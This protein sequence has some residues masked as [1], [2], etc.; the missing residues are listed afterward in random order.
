MI[1]GFLMRGALLRKST[2]RLV[3]GSITED[4]RSRAAV[5]LPDKAVF[6]LHRVIWVM[7]YGEPEKGLLVDHRDGDVGHNRIANFR[8]LTNR[9][10]QMN[11]RKAR[12][13]STVRYIGVSAHRNGFAAF[14]ADGE[15]PV[16]LGTFETPE[17]A[18]RVR[19]EEVERRYGS[20]ATLNRVLFGV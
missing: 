2:G 4:P 19:D 7:H 14:S 6:Y 9:Q 11:R 1:N 12:K 10:N 20:V 18:A 13:G 5:G 16:Y 15:K 3:F 17:E 8:L